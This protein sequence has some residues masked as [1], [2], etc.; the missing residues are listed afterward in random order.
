MWVSVRPRVHIQPWSCAHLHVCTGVSTHECTCRVHRPVRLSVFLC[1]TPPHSLRHGLKSLTILAGWT[2]SVFSPPGLGSQTHIATLD[3][4]VHQGWNSGPHALVTST[5][6]A[7]SSS[8][9]NTHFRNPEYL[10]RPTGKGLTLM[11]PTNEIWKR[12]QFFKSTETNVKLQ[13]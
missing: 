13:E 10:S 5:L 9:D 3:F 6:R 1:Y 8:Q 7:G 4:C 2:I 11:K 12:W